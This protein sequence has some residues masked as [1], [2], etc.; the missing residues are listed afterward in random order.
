VSD[1]SEDHQYVSALH[2]SHEIDEVADGSRRATLTLLEQV[3]ETA[4]VISNS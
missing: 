1:A 3:G 4:K 2:R